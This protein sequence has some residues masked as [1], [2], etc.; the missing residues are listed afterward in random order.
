[1]CR[2]LN[3]ICVS[4]LVKLG[5]HP[6]KNSFLEMAVCTSPIFKESTQKMLN[7]EQFA[8]PAKT[9]NKVYIYSHC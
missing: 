3:S 2:K 4:F 9:F 1:M 7:S 6:G 8:E 5:T